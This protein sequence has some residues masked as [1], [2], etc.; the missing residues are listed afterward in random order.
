M[1]RAVSLL[2]A[3]MVFMSLNGCGKKQETSTLDEPGKLVDE[4]ETA[5]IDESLGPKAQAVATQAPEAAQTAQ[6]AAQAVQ[7]AVKGAAA[8]VAVEKPTIK[9]VQTAL[10]NAGLYT[11]K[12]DGVQGPGTSK[13]VRDFQAQNKLAIDGKVGPKTWQAMKAY[14]VKT[15]AAVPA[16]PAKATGK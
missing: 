13:A 11:G 5:L 12:I 1:K 14:L 6:T 4:S 2:V 9:Q 3:G 10:T 15:P 16:A 7:P 8:A